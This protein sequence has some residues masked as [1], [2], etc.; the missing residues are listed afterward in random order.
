MQAQAAKAFKDSSNYIQVSA[1]LAQSIL[2]K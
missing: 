1:P 2:V